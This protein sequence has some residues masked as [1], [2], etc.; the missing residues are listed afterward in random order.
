MS[1][2]MWSVL[3]VAPTTDMR[4]IRRAYATALKAIDPD[5]DVGAFDLLRDAYEAALDHARWAADTEDATALQGSGQDP[6]AEHGI[7][8]RDVPTDVSAAFRYGPNGVVAPEINGTSFAFDLAQPIPADAAA[9]DIDVPEGVGLQPPAL[10]LIEPTGVVGGDI[11]IERAYE[12]L[13]DVLAVVGD[14]GQPVQM[15]QK[16][17]EI[18]ELRADR[19]L[20][21]LEREGID[22]QRDW[23]PY[24]ARL[25]A[26]TIPRSDPIASAFIGFFGWSAGQ[27]NWDTSDDVR[28]IVERDQ[29]NAFYGEILNPDHALHAAFVELSE[30]GGAQRLGR[31]APRK[32]VARL[33]KLAHE[34]YPSLLPLFQPQIL[35]DWERKLK[36]GGYQGSVDSPASA[37]PYLLGVILFI[38]VINLV[39]RS[40]NDD[41]PAGQSPV[42][43]ESI[44]SLNGSELNEGEEVARAL[45][46]LTGSPTIPAESKAAAHIDA[47]IK[48]N[49][50]V[51]RA[52]RE[53]PAEFRNRVSD[54]LGQRAAGAARVGSSELLTAYWHYKRDAA[55]R[56][57]RTK[58]S[59]ACIASL[60]DP[61]P[62]AD[63]AKLDERRR[64]L[65]ADAILEDDPDLKP[66]RGGERF[67]IGGGIVEKILDDT[68]LPLERVKA[69]MLGKGSDGD[70]CRVQIALIDQLLRKPD[71]QALATL[72]KL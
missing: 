41:K 53:T 71:A 46:I 30:P 38:Q 55:E 28:T 40:V 23:E 45:R 54:V 72:R 22:A 48:S 11:T 5:A 62:M 63:E 69:A 6:M 18:I 31:R 32:E 56:T 29:G 64:K 15:D 44:A 66:S 37:W 12:E 52:L 59:V 49:Y 19:M 42:F 2:T 7:V 68:K 20:R 24:I 33:I 47:L 35:D 10:T 57:R 4:T 51:T 50:G 60:D 61:L 36:L 16:A 34:R 13:V 58:G 43:V 14:D 9:I 8:Y 65:L 17:F 39:V 3:G 70:R 25:L 26:G 21:C 67:T 27:D 1:A